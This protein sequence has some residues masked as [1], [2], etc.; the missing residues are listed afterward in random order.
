MGLAVLLV[1]AGA[2]VAAVAGGE[3]AAPAKGS[4][5]K[6]PRLFGY[7]VVRVFPHD[8]QAF[9]Q[10]LIIRDNVL[11]ESTGLNGRSSLRKVQLETGAVL[12]SRP[13]DTQYFAEGLTDWG[14]RL[15]QLT[16]QTGLGF[17]YSR[18]RFALE[19]TF[20][21]A[22]EGWGLTQDGRRFIMS[23]GTAALRF[24]DPSTFRETGRLSV[25]DA[26]TPVPNLNELEV[27]KGQIYANVWQTDRIAMIDAAS[28]FVT[29]WIDLTGLLT[30][31]ERM[32]GVDVLNGIAYDPKSDR[33]FV[34]GKLW[35]K[36]FEIQVVPR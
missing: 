4:A 13:V 10:G 14:D 36:L 1:A 33:L 6:G 31:V 25:R 23:D 18:E 8:R 20:T 12:E 32:S 3:Q 21:Y 34:T 26:G 29:G 27:V 5:S 19:R 17:V 2:F 11:Y 30:P 35:P 24:L 28:G 15:V 7:K 16:W 22:G 9:T